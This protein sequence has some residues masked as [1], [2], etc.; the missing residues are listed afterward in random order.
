MKK[1]IAIIATVL[2]VF[3]GIAV[4]AYAA[5]VIGGSS[6]PSAFTAGTAA[7]LTVDPQEADLNGILPGQTLP[8]D[9]WV[10]NSNPVPVRVTGLTATFND[11]GVCAF[12]VAWP[13]SAYGLGASAGF[14]DVLNVSMGNA[15][16]A[17]Q[18]WAGMVTATATGTM[19]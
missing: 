13:N 17:C 9:V 4:T 12:T 14:W 16:P 19:P 11:G 3:A 18:G 6:A 10:A 5:Y 15:A 1:K 7:D 8:M 2:V